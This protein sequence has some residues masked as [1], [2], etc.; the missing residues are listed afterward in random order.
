MKGFSV[1]IEQ[2]TIDNTDYRRVLYTAERA[3]LVLMSIAPG[4]EIGAEVH[5]DNNQF[6]RFEAGNGKVIVDNQEYEV[7]DGSAVIVPAGARHNVV[8]MSD[9]EALKLYTIYSP[10]HHKDGIVQPTHETADASDEHFDG[11]TSE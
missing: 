9:S 3:Q 2:E 8:N 11:V 1:N 5:N 6:L 7:T 4:D 10:P